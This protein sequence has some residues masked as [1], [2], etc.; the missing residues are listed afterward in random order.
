MARAVIGCGAMKTAAIP[1]AH[2]KATARK[3]CAVL[4][5]AKAKVSARASRRYDAADVR[6]A[7]R[8]GSALCRQHVR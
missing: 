3:K 7:N 1:P 8:F 4:A 6:E 2:A 5:R